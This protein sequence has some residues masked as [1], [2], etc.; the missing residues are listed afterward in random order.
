VLTDFFLFLI[1]ES[2]SLKLKILNN[3]HSKTTVRIAVLPP[4]TAEKKLL[5]MCKQIFEMKCPNKLEGAI[6]NE[7][8][9]EI[10]IK[11]MFMLGITFLIFL[12]FKRVV[13]VIEIKKETIMLFIPII[14]VKTINETNKAIDPMI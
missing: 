13:S 3:L 1:S 4:I 9:N 11:F 6:I 7:Y 14:G 12:K 2:K 5:K 8:L 10:P